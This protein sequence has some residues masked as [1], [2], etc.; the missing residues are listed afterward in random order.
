M[1]LEK[2]FLIKWKKIVYNNKIY[3]CVKCY[4]AQHLNDFYQLIF[5]I[6]KVFFTISRPMSFV[7]YDQIVAERCAERCME[8]N[9]GKDNKKVGKRIDKDGMKENELR[10][11]FCFIFLSFFFFCFCLHTQKKTTFH[12]L[13]YH[14]RNCNW[15]QNQMNTIIANSIT[16][17]HL[18][19]IP[20]HWSSSPGL[21]SFLSNKSV[22]KIWTTNVYN[23]FQTN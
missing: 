10:R 11:F 7:H 9:K 21:P 3:L 4:T 1:V 14:Q 22:H 8:S 16:I 15:T 23:V 19:S 2:N 18:H 13:F 17:I 20:T 12:K 6:H 5:G